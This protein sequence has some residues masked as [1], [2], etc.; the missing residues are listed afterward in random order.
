MFFAQCICIQDGIVER[1]VCGR[2]RILFARELHA[3]FFA[4]QVIK[5]FTDNFVTADI[6]IIGKLGSHFRTFQ[7]FGRNVI[8]PKRRLFA[9]SLHIDKA[10][11][12]QFVLLR[13][14]RIIVP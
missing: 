11:D 3:R 2:Q 9:L 4:H 12:V 8:R 14:H 7:R 10:V 6:K 5:V 1:H 13:R